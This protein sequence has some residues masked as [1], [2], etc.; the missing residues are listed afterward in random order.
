MSAYRKG[1]MNR[2]ALLASLP[3]LVALGC[4]DGERAVDADGERTNSLRRVTLEDGT[5]CVI[6]KVGYAGG[7]S[8]DFP[9]RESAE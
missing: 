5:R 7:L 4:G 8:C 6:Y 1:I 3:L 2:M 9:S